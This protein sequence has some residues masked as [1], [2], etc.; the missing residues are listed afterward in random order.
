MNRPSWFASHNSTHPAVVA[1]EAEGA[2]GQPLGAMALDEQKAL[3]R[4]AA[5]GWHAEDPAL[6]EVPRI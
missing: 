1:T 6:G 4:L 3:G 5:R 2:S